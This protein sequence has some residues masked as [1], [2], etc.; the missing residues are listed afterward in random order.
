MLKEAAKNEQD[1]E[2]ILRGRFI[3]TANAREELNI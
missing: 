1:V 3:A 2:G